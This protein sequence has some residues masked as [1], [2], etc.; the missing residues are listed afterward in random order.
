MQRSVAVRGCH[1]QGIQLQERGVKS[2]QE[3][4]LAAKDSLTHLSANQT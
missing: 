4:E 3:S 1:S 2:N